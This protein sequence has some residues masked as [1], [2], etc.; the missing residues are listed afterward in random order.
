M[1][2]HAFELEA[3]LFKLGRQLLGQR[4]RKAELVGCQVQKG[5]TTGG[6]RIA[7]VLQHQAAQLPVHIFHGIAFARARNLGVEQ[8]RRCNTE[9]VVAKGPQAHGT[10]VGIADGDGLGCAPLLVDLLAGAE[11]VHITFEGGLK[12]LVPVL[13]VG[14]QWQGL[15]GEL[16]GAGAEHIGHLAFIHKQRHLRF[17]HHQHRTILNFHV[18]HGV[19]PRQGSVGLFGPLNDIN[20]L[21][22]DEV[23]YSHGALLRWLV[24]Q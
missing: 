4:L 13:Q 15:R 14:Q 23:H 22:L 11:K 21:F 20:K 9:A 2:R 7:D 18:L 17:T 10:K 5:D 1:H 3:D 16:I 19:A 8:G 6:N 12:Q 24:K